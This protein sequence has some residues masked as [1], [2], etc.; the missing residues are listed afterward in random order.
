MAW[1]MPW[2]MP[3]AT[4][5]PWDDVATAFCVRALCTHI[6]DAALVPLCAT[7]DQDW[8]VRVR[9]WPPAMADHMLKFLALK[10]G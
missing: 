5:M 6:N 4:I 9:R 3:W 7:Q 2:S 8:L 1:V 10:Q